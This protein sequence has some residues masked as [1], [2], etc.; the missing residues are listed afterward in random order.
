MKE[1]GDTGG[2]WTAATPVE[3]INIAGADTRLYSVRGKVRWH[4][5]DVAYPWNPAFKIEPLGDAHAIVLDTHECVLYETYDTSFKD[6]ELQA[7]SGAH[8]NLREPFK[9]LPSGAPSAMAS[10]LSLYAGMV[11]WEDLA[12]GI[13]H[14]LNFAPKAG[15]TAQ[16]TFV[17]PASSTDGQPFKGTSQFQIPYGARLRLKPSFDISKFGPQSRAIAQAMKTYG[18]Y[19]ADTGSDENAI[20]NAMPL[21]GTN[22]W[23]ARDLE[24]LN[25]IHITDFEVLTLGRIDRVPGH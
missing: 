3:Y 7:Y 1:A 19:V 14:A 12:H 16:W 6:G 4:R 5:F 17:R 20:Y 25:N 11:K 15:S 2:F 13:H 10:G 24:S 23:D 9:P 22:R 18:I 8:W 21:D